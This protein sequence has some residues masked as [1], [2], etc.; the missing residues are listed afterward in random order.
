MK[1]KILFIVLILT[2]SLSLLSLNVFSFDEDFIALA[3]KSS[4]SSCQCEITENI[5]KIGNTGTINSLYSVAQEGEAAKW[6]VIRPK[7][8]SLEEKDT[9]TLISPI[10]IPCGTKPGEY[11]LLTYIE[12]GFGLKKVLKQAVVVERC[13]AGNQTAEGAD[14]NSADSAG[15]GSLAVKILKWV[16][17]I[18]AGFVIIAIIIIIILYRSESAEDAEESAPGKKVKPKNKK[19]K[20]AAKTANKKPGKRK[21]AK[22][23]KAGKE[24]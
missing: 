2:L 23:K 4:V 6:S 20:A 1:P 10:N 17:Y 12:S 5:I 19:I 24:R 13:G 21:P 11:E 14:G 9:K 16:A 15:K 18:F 22:R 8:F 3:E 7:S